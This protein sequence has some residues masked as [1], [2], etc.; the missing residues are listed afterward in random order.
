[1][2]KSDKNFS[3]YITD[4]QDILEKIR[5][6]SFEIFGLALPILKSIQSGDESRFE[7]LFKNNQET[8]KTK[9]I[10]AFSGF[11][12][13][14]IQDARVIITFEEKEGSMINS[15]TRSIFNYSVGNNSENILD[16]VWAGDVYDVTGTEALRLLH[17]DLEKNLE[18][19]RTK[20]LMKMTLEELNNDE[21]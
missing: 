19:L 5:E 4:F 15:F 18:N 2:E 1:M 10:H 9:L 13:K 11:V 3:E 17:K 12:L 6:T 20:K 8:K 16:R 21:H 14:Q 7:E